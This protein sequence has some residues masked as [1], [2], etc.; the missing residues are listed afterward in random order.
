MNSSSTLLH[1]VSY[2]TSIL[3]SQL[4]AFQCNALLRPT[5]KS[6]LALKHVDMLYIT[7]KGLR[8]MVH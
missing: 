8:L 3:Q 5:V 6:Y 1:S 4:I 2:I 7:D